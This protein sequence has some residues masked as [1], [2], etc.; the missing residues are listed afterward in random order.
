MQLA[1]S[2]EVVWLC[3]SAALPPGLLRGGN[4]RRTVCPEATVA[5]SM[6]GSPMEA[7]AR[8]QQ[9]HAERVLDGIYAGLVSDQAALR[10]SSFDASK[11]L[12]SAPHCSCLC[13]HA[14]YAQ[15]GKAGSDQQASGLSAAC[16]CCVTGEPGT[17]W[18]LVCMC[19]VGSDA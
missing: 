1:I 9:Q 10:V 15:L 4:T 12:C 2:H 5:C 17:A 16:L 7:A 6:A 11:V 3:S 8:A 14:A 18:A 13:L 19:S